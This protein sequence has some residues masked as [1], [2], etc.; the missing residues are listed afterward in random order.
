M[1]SCKNKTISPIEKIII[2]D[3]FVNKQLVGYTKDST[4]EMGE[5]YSKD[6]FRIRVVRDTN[7]R[8]GYWEKSVNN[9]MI[10]SEEFFPSTGQLVSKRNYV[11]GKIEGSAKYYYEDGRVRAEGVFKNDDW[12]GEWKEYDER[13]KLVAITT[14][15]DDHWKIRQE[16]NEE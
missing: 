3:A 12:W 2:D 10:A 7:N 4:G 5:Y 13:G 9:K 14:Y 15:T 1:F 6:S 11:N 16:I 8:I